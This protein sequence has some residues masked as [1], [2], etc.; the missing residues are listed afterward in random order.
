MQ[1]CPHTGEE[2]T[3]TMHIEDLKEITNEMG[4]HFERDEDGKSY[5]DLSPEG[6]RATLAKAHL[7][8]R[9]QSGSYFG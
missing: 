5:L 1:I 9:Q 7:K 6:K 8:A 2:Y 3:T 4:F